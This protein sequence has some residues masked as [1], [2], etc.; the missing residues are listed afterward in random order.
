MSGF[1]RQSAGADPTEIEFPTFV[2]VQPDGTLQSQASVGSVS[3]GGIGTDSDTAAPAD[4]G[5]GELIPQS[6]RTN[7][8]LGELNSEVL[9]Q[10]TVL[11]D[12]LT[13]VNGTKP[14]SLAT[15]PL[16]TDA[17][18]ATLQTALNSLIGAENE[19]AADSDT[20]THSLNALLK[21]DL[22][23]RHADRTSVEVSVTTS[24]DNAATI[25]APAAGNRIVITDLRIQN[26]TAD[27]TTILFKSGT[28]TIGSLITTATGG[29]LDKEYQYGNEL[30]L[31]T[32][33][34]FVINLSAA[35]SHRVTVRY[36]VENATTGLPI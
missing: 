3:V 35:N 18:T 2:S 23:R 30:R 17:A 31:G 28:T 14:V 24:G 19:S 15:V 25:A 6:K 7:I 26:T 8:E 20:G 22:A 5:N 36:Y 1:Y 34:A 27:E 4:G 21:R 12:I 13:Q 16:A 9:E 10:G 29:G 32:A 11:D 33:E